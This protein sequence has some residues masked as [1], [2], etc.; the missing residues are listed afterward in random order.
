MNDSQ[1]PAGTRSVVIGSTPAGTPIVY[2]HSSLTIR[3]LEKCLVDEWLHSRSKVE[4]GEH[5]RS[6]NERII[7]FAINDQFWF[8]RG[9]AASTTD[10]VAEAVFSQL[11]RDGVV[12]MVAEERDLWK[13]RRARLEEWVATRLL[14]LSG[15]SV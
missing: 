6:I 13:V 15:G 2:T 1:F 7:A 8:I 11:A 4:A 12:A 3:G 10:A 9:G 5:L 14:V